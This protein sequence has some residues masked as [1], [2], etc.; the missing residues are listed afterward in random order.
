MIRQTISIRLF[1]LFLILLTISCEELEVDFDNPFEVDPSEQIPPNT[2]TLN[3]TVNGSTADFIWTGNDYAKEFCYMLEE[4][5][6]ETSVNQPYFDWSDWSTVTSKQFT[7]LD[8]GIYTFTVKSRFN[9]IEEEEP[10]SK[11]IEINNIPGPALRIYPLKQ[12]ANSGDSID[13]YLYFEEVHADSAVSGMQIEIQI[14]PVDLQYLPS[15]F[16]YDGLFSQYSAESFPF[17]PTYSESDGLGT[18]KIIA[19]VVGSGLSGTGSILKFK[20]NVLAN[21]GTLNINIKENSSLENSNGRSIGF[22]QAVSGVVT[23]GGAGL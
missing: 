5:S 15:S 7:E 18:I 12:T 20:L 17:S 9:E 22:R 13:V 6:V 16:G 4:D 11:D 23:I 1:S 10:L 19:G 2:E 14:D 21:D 8:E 3:E